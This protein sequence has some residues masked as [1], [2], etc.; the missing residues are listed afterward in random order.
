M[1]DREIMQQALD[2]LWTSANPKAE[3]VITSLTERLAQPEQPAPTNCRHCGGP[4]NVICAG[5][6]KEQPAQ[7][8]PLT[9]EQIDELSR[10]MVKG[11]KSVNWLCRAIEV[12]HGIFKD[13]K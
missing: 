13:E 3:A 8:K 11:S 5:Q 12:A 4:D 1:T 7:R 2:A 10:T 9:D 6:C